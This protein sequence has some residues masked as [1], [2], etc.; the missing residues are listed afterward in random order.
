MGVQISLRELAFIPFQY[1][2]LS[3]TAVLCSTYIPIGLMTIV[4]DLND[5]SSKDMSLS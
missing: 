4:N 1:I 5:G 3:G 2:T